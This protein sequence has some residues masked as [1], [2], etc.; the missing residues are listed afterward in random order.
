MTHSLLAT[1][2]H[3]VGLRTTSHPRTPSVIHR[4]E[5]GVSILGPQGARLVPITKTSH[6]GGS[7]LDLAAVRYS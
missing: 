3:H 5:Q 1:Y 7:G 6:M 2:R 4:P